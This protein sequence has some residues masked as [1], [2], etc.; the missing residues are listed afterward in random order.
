M[1]SYVREVEELLQSKLPNIIN[2]MG[3]L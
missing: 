2:I 1:H 3:T